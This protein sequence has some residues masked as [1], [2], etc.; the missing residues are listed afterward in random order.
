MKEKIRHAAILAA[1]FLVA[2]A[3]FSFITG[4]G[5]VD[6]TTEMREA[7]LPRITLSSGGY[8]INPLVG[9]VSEMDTGRMRDTVTPV[10]F[11]E[12]LDVK[13]DFDGSQTRKI[14]YEV[15]SQ[16]GKTLLTDGELSGIPGGLRLDFGGFALS[17]REAVLK[18]ILQR[19]DQKLYYYTRICDSR[20]MNSDANLEF[21]ERFHR[22]TFDK[23]NEE[24]IASYLEHGLEKDGKN[25]LHRVTIASDVDHITWGDMNVEV[26]GEVCRSIREIS[27]SDMTL[28]YDYEVR[29]LSD[30]ENSGRY[31]V[32]EYMKVRSADGKDYLLDYERTMDEVFD[33]SGKALDEKGLLLGIASED[34]AYMT[35]KSGTIV[36]FVQAGELWNY[37]QK[38]DELALVFSFADAEDADIRNRYRGH[39][40][41]LVSVNDEGDTT[42]RVTGYMNRGEHEGRVGT[43]VYF[44]DIQKNSVKETAFLPDN[45]SAELLLRERGEFVYYNEEKEILYG[46][47]S[48]TLYRA[49]LGEKN[50]KALVENLGEGQYAASGD[51]RFFAYQTD[52]PVEAATQVKVIDFV[53]GDVREESCADTEFVRPLG[54]IGADFVYGIGAKSDVGRRVTGERVVPMYKLEIRDKKNEIVKTYQ[55]EQTYVTD[56]FVERKLLT[57]ERVTRTGEFYAGV[58]RD[59]ITSNEEIEES[60]ILVETYTSEPEERQIRLRYESGI[61][62]KEPKLLRPKQVLQERPVVLEFETDGSGQSFYA[63]GKGRLLGIFETAAAAI[64]EADAGRGLVVSSDQKYVWEHGSH[65]PGY[66]NTEVSA[67]RSPDENSVVAALNQILLFEGKP[68][69]AAAKIA[70]GRL[71]IEI[72]REGLGCEVL[73]LNKCRT[74]ELYDIIGRGTP[75]LAMTDY[76]SAVILVGYTQS[77]VIYLKPD[78]GERVSIPSEE[79]E[80]LTEASGN[81]YI[82]YLK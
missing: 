1:V 48:G 50:K 79:L 31:L 65:A 45:C 68:A 32:R 61:S 11:A 21:A 42:F 5:N 44:Y 59:Y 74:E 76:G 67:Y 77:T 53:T 9:Y 82:G 16:D 33:A 69:D 10:D 13:L 55:A 19:E 39:E 62:D 58:T 78:T 24:A 38:S 8:E 70:E 27:G 26:S 23:E 34:V 30:T 43:A 4:R 71:P 80:A 56:V 73:D 60:N 41:Q 64:A 54:F 28:V 52:S 66:E 72:L 14:S 46:M 18:I 6:R 49:A 81:S 17:E 7:V 25:S 57:L 40:I 22:M 35:D 20:R 36:S 15:Y 37:N 2:V 3:A 29:G 12:G 51:G 75:I 63:Y 47:K